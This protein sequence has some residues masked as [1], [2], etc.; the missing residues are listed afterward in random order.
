[1]KIKNEKKALQMFCSKD[2]VL[3]QKLARPFINELYDGKVIATDCYLLLIVDPKLLRCKYET[4]Q[5]QIPRMSCKRICVPI[6]FKAVDEAYEQLE[7]IPEE[8]SEDGE[9]KECPECAGSGTVDWEYID[10]HGSTHYK[11]ATC[12]ICDGTGERED[13]VPVKTGRMILP[14][15]S[16]FLM[17]QT[18]FNANF[19]M[20]AVE[21]LRLMG[22]ESMTWVGDSVNGMNRFNVCDGVDLVIMPVLANNL[23]QCVEIKL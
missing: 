15:Y 13:Y 4:D 20:R 10:S 22:F 3:H 12:P 9:P 23:S 19:V 7:K 1:M 6:D 2:T 16:A 8:V 21:A 17:G 18:Y 11:D 14:E 5:Q